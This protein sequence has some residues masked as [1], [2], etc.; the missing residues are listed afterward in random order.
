MNLLGGR[1]L[2]LQ[3]TWVKCFVREERQLRPWGREVARCAG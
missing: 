3:V 2:A 1:E